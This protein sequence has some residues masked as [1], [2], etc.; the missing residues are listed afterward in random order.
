MLLSVL[1]S[2]C[3][4]FEGIEWAAVESVAF[5]DRAEAWVCIMGGHAVDPP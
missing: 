5:E 1:D 2:L 3:W 4:D